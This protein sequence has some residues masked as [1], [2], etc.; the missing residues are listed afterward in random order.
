MQSD[1]RPVFRPRPDRRRTRTGHGSDGRSPDRPADPHPG[2]HAHRRGRR[3]VSPPLADLGESFLLHLQA[4][5]RSRGTIVMYTRI[6]DRFTRFLE[7][8]LGH[9][10]TGDAL[11]R[12]SARGYLVHLQQQPR[13]ADVPERCGGKLAPATLNQHA[14]ALRAFAHWLWDEGFTPEHRLERLRLPKVPQAEI[15]PLTAAEVERL[16][17]GVRSAQDLRPAHGGDRGAAGGHRHADWGTRGPASRGRQS[18]HRRVAGGGQGGEVRVVVAGRRALSLLRRYLHHRPPGLGQSS[19]RL[20]VTASGR[21]LDTAQV[22]HIV[23]RLRRRS[24]IPR[25]YAHLLRHTFAVHFLRNGG[26]P[27]TLQRLLGQRLAG[28][29]QPLRDAGDGR[30]GGGPPAQQPARQSLGE[31]ADRA[32]ELAEALCQCRPGAHGG[33]RRRACRY[34]EP[35]RRPRIRRGDG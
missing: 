30:P 15:Q 12:H 25:L 35:L 14:R 18:P 6:L 32:V 9:A 29:H 24:G 34:G 17:R 8:Q 22:S 2:T 7:A 4:S 3:A 23:R 26:N 16:L 28:D 19:D 21:A 11:S 5:R 13:F 33:A 10:P 27:L 1:Q 31:T 20:F